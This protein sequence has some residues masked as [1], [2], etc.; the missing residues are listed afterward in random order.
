MNIYNECDLAAVQIMSLTPMSKGRKEM[1]SHSINHQTS[2]TNQQVYGREWQ[3][4]V[5]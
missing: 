3:Q 1:L 2:N 4:Q 5:A